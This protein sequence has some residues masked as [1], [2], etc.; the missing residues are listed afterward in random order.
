MNRGSE[1]SRPPHTRHV[2]SMFAG[3]RCSV[4]VVVGAA[5]SSIRAPHRHV[6]IPIVEA[7]SSRLSTLSHTKYIYSEKAGFD[8]VRFLSTPDPPSP[9][10]RSSLPLRRRRNARCLDKPASLYSSLSS[11]E[12][13]PKQTPPRLDRILSKLTSL[14]PL[15]VLGSAILGSYRP[16][17][18]NWVNRGNS[19]SYMLAGVMLGTGMTLE[20]ADFTNILACPSRRTS[21]PLGVLCQFI[22]MPLSAAMIGRTF[23]LPHGEPLGKHL[24]LGLVLVGCS[25]GG[26]ASNLVSL[27]AGADVALSVLL[28]ACST[29]LASVVTPLLTKWILGS[30]VAVSGRSLC[31]ATAK[32][33]LAPVTLG[34][35]LNE[36]MPKLSRWISRFTPFASVLLVGLIC[37][38]VVAN[39]A[40]MMVGTKAGAP[41][42]PGLVLASVI[43]THALGFAA[44][45]SVPHSLGFSE[46]TSRTISIE[47]GMQNSALAVVLAK[48][49]G[50]DPLSCLPGAVSATVHSCL[51]SG[52][53]AFWRMRDSRKR[54]RMNG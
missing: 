41:S 5:L 28:T 53:A 38:G 45:Y 2:R 11:A 6:A 31:L 21:I 49:I 12:E 18:L 47:T 36:T 7:F 13:E 33:V 51:G 39:N 29:V 24:F 37:G 52:L 44:G 15:F 17:S 20:R 3:T 16:D 34:V 30:T 19:I 42:L 10:D 8:P 25:P 9:S 32:V 23:L 14:F 54:K 50:A 22:L 40:A 35:I 26:T 46:T 27:I 43:A 4:I 1:S 48:S